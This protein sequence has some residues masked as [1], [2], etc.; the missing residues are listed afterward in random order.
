M[1][2]RHKDTKL[3]QAKLINRSTFVI[4]SYISA[5]VAKSTFTQSHKTQILILFFS[6][7]LLFGSTSCDF[8]F[9]SRQDDQVD[10]I[11][12]QG[13]IDPNLVPQ[14]VGYVP[15]MPIWSNFSNP[16]D[17]FV[18]YDEMIY[19]VDDKGLNILDLKGIIH[20][21]IKINKA[22]EVIQDRR[23][24]TYVTGKVKVIINGQEKELACIYHLKNTAT[25][26]PVFVDT[27][28][29][30]FC[31]ASRKNIGFRNDDL[32]VEFTGLAVRADNI[33]YVS[34]TGPVN[35]LTSFAR[36]DNTI[37]F[38]DETGKNTG[39]T[40]GLNPVTP[41]LKSVLGVSSIAG[42][43]G[44]PQKLYGV[45]ESHDFIL[46]QASQSQNIEY[47]VLWIKETSDPDAGTVYGENPS[48]LNLDRTK[49]DGFLYDLNKFKKPEDIYIAPDQSG[50]IF[51]VDSGKDSLFVFTNKGYEG[52]NPPANSTYKKNI[53]VSFGGNG[54]GIFQFK[55]PS[56][57][58][59]YKQIVY[60]ADKGNNRIMRYR[61]NTDLE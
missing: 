10:Q 44:P 34:R 26:S 58:C 17:I 49:A 55:S 53:I 47:R 59:Y 24:H 20:N 21:T 52:V 25:N 43:V 36:P 11:F 8:L 27:L 23:I 3:H 19:V 12:Q 38:Y 40:N 29:H 31:D 18:G 46:C 4:S 56:G 54:H 35:D 61:L 57:V 42:F 33:L 14:N 28:I 13:K 32:Q 2:Q 37:L 60:V 45:N 50:Y 16:V 22:K 1:P 48:M 9:G 41:N 7:F 39:Y 51:V 15:I 6:V 30:P 5:L